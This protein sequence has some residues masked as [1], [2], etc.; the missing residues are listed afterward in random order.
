MS[1]NRQILYII[2]HMEKRLIG[3]YHIAAME[4]IV[5]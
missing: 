3:D 1:A 4:F 2:G 5:D